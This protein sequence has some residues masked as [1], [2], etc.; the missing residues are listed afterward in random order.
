MIEGTLCAY[1]FQLRLSVEDYAFAHFNTGRDGNALACQVIV[2]DT[3]IRDSYL[4][5]SL[6]DGTGDPRGLRRQ[7]GRRPSGLR[8][9]R[10]RPVVADALALFHDIIETSPVRSDITAD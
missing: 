3:E 10:H 1:Y 5:T 4:T 7:Q 2:E 8:A 9:D 6:S